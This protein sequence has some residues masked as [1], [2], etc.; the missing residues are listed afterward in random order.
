MLHGATVI[1]YEGARGASWR[2]KYRDATGK[3]V[4]ETLGREPAWNRTRAERELGKRLAAVEEGFRKPDKLTFTAFTERFSDYLPGRNLKLTTLENYR[5]MLDRHLIPHFGQRQLADVEAQP[6]LIDAYI[7]LKRTQGLAPKT[8]QNHL[9]LL[10]LMLRRATAWRLIRANP[11]ANVDRPRLEQ[12]EINVLTETEIA[13]LFAA[14]DQLLETAAPDQL[15]WWQLANSIVVTALGTAMRRG[16]LLGLRWRAVDLLEGKVHVREAHIRGQTTTPKSRAS[17]RVIELGPRTR[18]ALE[19][20][21]QRARYR[22][23]GNLVFCH[24]Q[25]GTPLDP[26]KLSRDYL[27]PALLAA[28]LTKRPRPFHDLRHTSLTHT[29][30]AGNPQI[31]V[32][33]R[34]GHAHASITERYM[35]AAQVMFPAAAERAEHRIFG[36][37]TP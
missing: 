27:K 18:T 32:Q 19:Q 30:A 29:A 8:I 2:I 26:S 35:H 12:P 5:Y 33:A 16:E 23:D 11:L 20:Q 34:A 31:Y 22:D 9:L 10:N 36:G 15:P 24:P 1:R 3:Q 25:R 28:G 21:G 4:Q 6:E 14:Y 37:R 7:A 13:R 17:R